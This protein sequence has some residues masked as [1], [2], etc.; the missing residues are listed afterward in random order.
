[1][2]INRRKNDM[3]RKGHYQRSAAR[4]SRSWTWCFL[5]R[6]SA[7]VG[8]GLPRCADVP[9]RAG[10][11]GGAGSAPGPPISSPAADV[12]GQP[13]L[14]LVQEAQRLGSIRS[15]PVA[16]KL[17]IQKA[18]ARWL[19]AWRPG[20]PA[21]HCAPWLLLTVVVTLGCQ[22][23]NEVARLQVCDV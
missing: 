2:H 16:P 1:M 10:L 15:H 11:E 12:R 7:D 13:I 6:G 5:R 20:T 9:S 8:L 17:P 3:Q 21:P 14:A 23:V 22:R 4:V 19:L 18:T